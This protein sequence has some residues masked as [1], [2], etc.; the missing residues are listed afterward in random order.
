MARDEQRADVSGN[1]ASRSLGLS[2]APAKRGKLGGLFINR[3]RR[4]GAKIYADADANEV[5]ELKGIVG[6][7]GAAS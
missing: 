6:R 4:A 1:Y 2:T 5:K 7:R 3:E